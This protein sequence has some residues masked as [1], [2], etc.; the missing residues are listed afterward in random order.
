MTITELLAANP[1]V[2]VSLAY[3]ETLG[4]YTAKSK[5]GFVSITTT[6]NDHDEEDSPGMFLEAIK[7]GME[8]VK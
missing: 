8:A 2:E 1:G 6:V 3:N 4:V 7:R 5:I